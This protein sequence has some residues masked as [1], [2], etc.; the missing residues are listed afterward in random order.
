MK[1]FVRWAK[2]IQIIVEYNNKNL[3]PLLVVFFHFLNPTING[4]IEVAPIDD[5][6]I[7]GV[8][9]SNATTLHKLLKNELHL[10]YHLHVKPKEFVLPLTC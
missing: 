10:F 2:M 1:E 9:T 6:A 3:L 8:M 5:D 4:L 7:F